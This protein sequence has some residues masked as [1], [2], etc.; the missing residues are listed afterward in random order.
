MTQPP[1]EVRRQIEDSY[2]RMIS[3]ARYRAQ[4]EGDVLGTLTTP[5][6]K[7]DP[8]QEARDYAERWWAEEAKG[9]FYIGGVDFPARPAVV[10]AVEA[11]RL[12]AAMVP[13]KEER[14]LALLKMAVDDVERIIKDRGRG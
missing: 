6:D 2:R 8:R 1:G 9:D 7:L 4:A 5:E 3:E 10:F 11:S 13:G 14:A 12:L